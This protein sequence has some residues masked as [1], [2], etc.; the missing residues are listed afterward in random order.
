[1]DA[2]IHNAGIYRAPSR[3]STPEGHASMEG[4]CQRVAGEPWPH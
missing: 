3:G 4:S 1:M 2:V